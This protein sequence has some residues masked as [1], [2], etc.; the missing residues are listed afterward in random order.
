M[1]A[2]AN[3]NI[4]CSERRS[5]KVKDLKEHIRSGRYQVD[6]FKVAQAML[7]HVDR[8]VEKGVELALAFH[9]RTAIEEDSDISDLL[10]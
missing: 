6:V 1:N 5:A 3:K 8:G 2:I 10:K 4:S 9:M 7:N